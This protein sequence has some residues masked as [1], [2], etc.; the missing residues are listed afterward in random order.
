MNLASLKRNL[1]KDV[2]DFMQ[3]SIGLLGDSPTQLLSLA[4]RGYGI[5]EKINFKLFE[6]EYNQIDYLVFNTSSELYELKP[7]YL[8][9]S[10]SSEKLIQKFY[11]SSKEDQIN[12]AENQID[13]IR[14]YL[15]T[16][17]GQL[18]CTVIYSNFMEINDNVFGNYGNKTNSSFLSQIRRINILLQELTQ[19]FKN[20]SIN[21]LSSLQNSFGRNFTFSP[22]L[23]A[24]TGMVH[25]T[26]FLPY[27]AKNVVEII[28]ANKGIINKCLILDLD[29]T[30]W[31]GIIGDDGMEGIQIG[32]LGIGETFS[33][34]QMWVKQ[35]KNRGII[36]A[37][38]SKNEEKAAKEPFLSHPDMIL[39]IEDIA[40]FVANWDN[41]A[42]NIRYIQSVLNIGFDS[43]VFVDDNPVERKIVRENLPDITVPELPKDPAEYLCYLQNLN[44]FET[45]SYSEGDS[46][47]TRQYQEESNRLRE[48][49]SFV[50]EDDFLKSL[51][52]KAFVSNFQKNDIPRIAQLSQRS[53]QFN[54]RTIRFSEDE[55]SLMV[56][57]DEYVTLSFKLTDSYGDNGLV[58]VII[59]EKKA[60]K[61]YLINTWLMS[62]RVLKRG[63][64]HLVLN[65]IVR[66]VKDAGAEKLIGEYIPTAKNEMVKNH[67]LNLGFK[68]MGN[69][70]QYELE[71]VQYIDKIH[72]IEKK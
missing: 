72:F 11:K 34:F 49:K 33:R 43:M 23:Y 32:N 15:H 41:K 6:A 60:D 13:K 4:L 40:V 9:I 3:V 24:N 48:K 66:Q 62:C 44:L 14:Q 31:G 71:V 55:L 67:Y 10:E 16:I 52:M 29:N 8:L 51:E 5:E 50:N 17:N 42:D 19:D 30:T 69:A 38:C 18:Q 36:L 47:R 25:S 21:D 1:K 46:D 57:K 7:K 56:L 26:E 28:K 65:E 45:A 63:L 20:L 68:S 54:L 53:N 70:N 22:T 2:N 35:L 59:L 61:V 64:E 39:R 58:C 37:I 27:L 12:F